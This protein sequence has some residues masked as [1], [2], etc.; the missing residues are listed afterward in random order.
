MDWERSGKRMKV[1]GQATSSLMM[2]EH[3]IQNMRN[4]GY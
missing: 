2:I 4:Y 1:D 3:E